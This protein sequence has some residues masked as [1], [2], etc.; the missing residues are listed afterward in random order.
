MKRHTQTAIFPGID[1]IQ[2]SA[3]FSWIDHAI[4]FQ[5]ICGLSNL[6]DCIAQHAT[7]V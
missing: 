4:S 2:P 3:N 6:I 5:M 1:Q 7:Y